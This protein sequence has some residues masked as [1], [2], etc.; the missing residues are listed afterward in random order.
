M[1][2]EDLNNDSYPGWLFRNYKTQAIVAVPAS[3]EYMGN[4]ALRGEAAMALRK[5]FPGIELSD[6]E[7][8]MAQW[9][10]IGTGLDA[11]PLQ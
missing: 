4:P 1:D 8:G 10:E 6:A 9:D 3:V 2:T 5:R 11:Q 7:A